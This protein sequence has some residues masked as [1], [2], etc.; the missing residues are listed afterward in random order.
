[1]GSNLLGD[2]TTVSSS[3]MKQ[4]LCPS[5]A[6]AGVKGVWERETVS[7]KGDKCRMGE[8]KGVLRSFGGLVLDLRKGQVKLL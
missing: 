1:M 6:L 2:R 5:G 8:L 4:S 3:K 7:E